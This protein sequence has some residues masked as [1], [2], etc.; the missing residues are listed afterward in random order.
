MAVGATLFGQF[1]WSTG[2]YYPSAIHCHDLIRAENSAH[3]RS[4][5]SDPQGRITYQLRCITASNSACSPLSRP[6]PV[7][8]Y[9]AALLHILTTAQTGRR[10]FSFSYTWRSGL[11]RPGCRPAR[12]DRCGT[13]RRTFSGSRCPGRSLIHPRPRDFRNSPNT[14]RPPAGNTARSF[15]AVGQEVVSEPVEEVLI[16]KGPQRVEVVRLAENGA[17]HSLF[18]HLVSHLCGT[19]AEQRPSRHPP[20]VVGE[21]VRLGPGGLMLI[22]EPAALVDIILQQRAVNGLHQPHV[23]GEGETAAEQCVQGGVYFCQ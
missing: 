3:S 17:A 23:P 16:E 5:G 7:P 21:E 13:S 20:A 1:S 2:R 6:P 8:P 15:A 14:S 22:R 19:A 9:P 12:W 11:C 10:S 18:Q 4:I